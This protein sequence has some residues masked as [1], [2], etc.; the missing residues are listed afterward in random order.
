MRLV[1]LRYTRTGGRSA[2]GSYEGFGVTYAFLQVIVGC[3]L[4]LGVGRSLVH[5]FISGAVLFRGTSG[6][7]VGPVG[8]RWGR[9]EGLRPPSFRKKLIYAV[10]PQP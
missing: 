1:W 8:Y 9:W 2:V 7:D 10:S 5:M 6:G 4:C 3:L